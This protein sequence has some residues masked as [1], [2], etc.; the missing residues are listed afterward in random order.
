MNV[1][2]YY[3]R[4]AT[5]AASMGT[6]DGGATLTLRV[7]TA[8]VF[9]GSSNLLPEGILDTLLARELVHSFEFSEMAF[10]T[11]GFNTADEQ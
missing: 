1:E 9:D 4:V 7:N 10:S 2:Y 6:A 11:D 5:T 8:Q 3:D